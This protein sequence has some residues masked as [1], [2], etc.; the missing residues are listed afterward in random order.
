MVCHHADLPE[1]QTDNGVLMGPNGEVTSP[2][3]MVLQSD[4]WN[5]MLHDNLVL[6][7]RPSCNRAATFVCSLWQHW[8]SF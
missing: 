1:F 4:T 5:G 3:I 2:T 8:I 6:I 7:R